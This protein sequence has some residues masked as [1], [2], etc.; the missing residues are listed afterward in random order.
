VSAL[1]LRAPV[2]RALDRAGL[3]DRLFWLRARLG[4][5]GLVVLTY[6]RIG[7]S[8]GEGELDPGVVD[9][10]PAELSAELAVLRD[11]ATVVSMADVHRA[12]RGA[13]LPPNAALVTFDDGY[14]DAELAIPLLRRAGVPATFFIPTAFPDGG[15][16]FWWDRVWLTLR[17]C[18][19]ARFELTYPERLTLH[20]RRGLAAAARLLIDAVKRA[21][22]LDLSRLW[23]GL[24]QASGVAL[25]AAEERAI[26]ARTIL[27]WPAVRRLHDAGLDVQSHSHDHLILNALSPEGAGRDLQRSARLLR[28]LTG[29][30]PTAVAYPVGYELVGAHRAAPAEAGF[31]LGFTNGTGLCSPSRADPFNVPRVSMDLG[32]GLAGY[33]A[34]L[35]LG[36]GRWARPTWTAGPGEPLRPRDAPEPEPASAQA[37]DA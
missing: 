32:L 13:R 15:R 1:G 2:E 28:D 8:P 30:A 25:D 24:E 3:L 29:Q 37:R 4:R 23:E 6:H 21:D 9:A 12:F 5:R 27:G 33:K 16:L 19:R 36:D 20:P 10:T 11:Q 14:A 17:R 26:A 7:M 18:R 34:R 22:R 35:L 31:T